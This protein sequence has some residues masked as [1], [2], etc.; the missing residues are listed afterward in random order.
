MASFL[1]VCSSSETNAT[2][3]IDFLDRIE[4][5]A[6]RLLS[7]LASCRGR[8]RASFRAASSASKARVIILSTA[9]LRLAGPAK[10]DRVWAKPFPGR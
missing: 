6:V 8:S 3:M 10:G 2:N 9:P 5:P 1:A 4:S 7:S